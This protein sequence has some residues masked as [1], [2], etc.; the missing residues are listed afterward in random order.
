MESVVEYPNHQMTEEELAG[1]QS[2]RYR[3]ELK[4]TVKV[5]Q[6]S[7]TLLCKPTSWFSPDVKPVYEGLYVVGSDDLSIMQ[8][9]NGK[10][11][12]RGDGSPAGWQEV[13]WRGW[14]GE[15]V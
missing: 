10:Q 14:T 2:R 13:P 6:G 1:W 15:Y 12:V 8:E 11:W 5:Y 4:N 7:K 3:D 9:W